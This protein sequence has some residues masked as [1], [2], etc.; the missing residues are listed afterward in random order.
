MAV[1]PI[2]P[3][4]G[5]EKPA[6]DPALIAQLE[7]L[8]ALARAGDVQAFFCCWVEQE[9]LRDS[10]CTGE[11]EWMPALHW[12]LHKGLDQLREDYD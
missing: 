1:I 5:E 11:S 2:K 9:G 3:G 8:L 7:D 6:P 12:E 10:W 4:H